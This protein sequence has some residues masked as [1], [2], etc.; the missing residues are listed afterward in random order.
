VKRLLITI[1]KVLAS[2]AIVGWLVYS[3]TKGNK[4]G[5]NVFSNLRE[6]PKQWDML[7]AAWAFC[8]F[9]TILTFVRWFFLIR[10]LGIPCA[11][12][13]S[14]RISFW[15]YL[16]NLLPL[17]IVGGD[18]IKTVMLDH[19]HR[20]YRAKALASVLVDRIIGLWVLFVFAS[21]GIYFTGFWNLVTPD[22]HKICPFIFGLKLDIHTI[23]WFTYGVTIAG[24]IGL[25]IILGPDLSNGRIVQ[26]IGRIPRVGHPLESLITAVRMYNK[27][28]MVLLV[29]SIMTIG[30]HGSFAIG[31]Y[32]IAC[33]LPGNH[34]S[35]TQHF[36]VMPLSAAMQVIPL[37]IGPTESALDY[38]YQIV[39]A[40]GPAIIVGQ[41]LVVALAYRI[42]TV[43]IAAMGIRYYFT[44]RG[45]MKDV[46][47]EAE[48]EEAA[49]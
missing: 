44:N 33:G 27:K 46:M 36:V 34:L 17:G 47:H 40:A 35:L 26:S 30:V 11:F 19:E 15:G 6:Q 24:T 14:I 43:L 22:P 3:A 16:F 37:P 12:R 32:F 31:C 10:A 20:G 49:V 7:A 28:P 21:A 2:A 38:L 5:G 13:D 8:F 25:A 39:P 23:C 41:G 42:I 45:E 1:L 4:Q 18:L 9:A 48:A 29:S